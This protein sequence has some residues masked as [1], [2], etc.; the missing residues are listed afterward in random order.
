MKKFFKIIVINFSFLFVIFLIAELFCYFYSIF[1]MIS[2]CNT[3]GTKI[4]KDYFKYKT[5]LLF[6]EKYYQ[7]FVKSDFKSYYPQNIVKNPILIMG[8]SFAYGYNL[9]EKDTLSYK[10]S[11][12]T[13]RI[14][15]N[16]A[17]NG[18]SVQ[19]AIL[20]AEDNSLYKELSEPEYIIYVYN[21]EIHI[22]RLYLYMLNSW[23]NL[24]NLRYEVQNQKLVRAKEKSFINK[25]YLY[26]YYVKY[27]NLHID[28]GLYTED[29]LDFVLMHFNKFKEEI[30]KHWTKTKYVILF[31]N[32][33]ES[34][35]DF[36]IELMKQLQEKGFIVLNTKDLTNIALGLEYQI[37]EQD[38][39]P[40]AKA[41]ELIV[42]N[43]VKELNL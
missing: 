37:S 30:Q 39:H 19:Q 13:Q 25:L 36:D 40:N 22:P 32:C 5:E 34:K 3:T 38:G 41:W 8:C 18:A 12:Q 17:I 31:Y 28:K 26:N 6:Y 9:E 16:R 2:F 4:Q 33:S 15:Y 24:V 43:L 11:E 10:L 1:E 27:K 14:V 35:S 21:S 20:Q 23:E 7:N 29:N 42:P